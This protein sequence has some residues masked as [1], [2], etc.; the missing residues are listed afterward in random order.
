MDKSPFFTN[1]TLTEKTDDGGG[2]SGAGGGA[3]GGGGGGGG[4]ASL[5]P[6]GGASAPGPGGNSAPSNYGG[7][8][9]GEVIPAAATPK[10]LDYRLPRFDFQPGASIEDF[11]REDFTNHPNIRWKFE[12]TTTLQTEIVN[13]KVEDDTAKIEAL[14]D[15]VLNT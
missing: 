15:E 14:I 12:V 2:D 10:A 1:T 8:I 4:P 3:G 11:F 6:G 7:S 5:G 9:V 13:Q